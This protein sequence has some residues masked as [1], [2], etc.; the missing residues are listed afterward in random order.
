VGGQRPANVT[1]ST[2]GLDRVAWSRDGRTLFA[3][4]DVYDANDAQWRDLLFAWDRSGRVT[5]SE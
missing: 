3:A 2:D 4:G 1:H 5:S